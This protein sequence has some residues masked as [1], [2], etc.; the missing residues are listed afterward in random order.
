MIY[1]GEPLGAAPG[2]SGGGWTSPA[3]AGWRDAVKG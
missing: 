1:G 3:F 2:G